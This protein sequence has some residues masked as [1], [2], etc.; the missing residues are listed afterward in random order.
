M[1]VAEKETADEYL[2]GRIWWRHRGL[3]IS[4]PLWKDGWRANA[5]KIPNRRKRD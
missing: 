1:I 4:A 5:L 3:E 2:P